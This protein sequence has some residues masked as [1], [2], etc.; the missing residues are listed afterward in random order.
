[1]AFN[2]DHTASGDMT[3][4]GGHSAFVG[5]FTFPKPANIGQEAML[6]VGGGLFSIEAIS[7][8]Q[9]CLDSKVPTGEFKSA[10]CKNAENSACSILLLVSDGMGG[11]LLAVSTIPASIQ[12]TVF[13]SPD[14]N[15]L[16]NLT[17]ANKGDFAT[18]I[19]TSSTYVLTG[20]SFGNPANW[21]ELQNADITIDSVNTE[22]PDTESNYIM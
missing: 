22:E 15:G 4:V 16:T 18:V 7:G 14:V 1:M 3:F 6:M 5:E 9:A 20:S 19:A 17:S 11:G 13:V 10:G 21:L 2:F 8:L 12:N